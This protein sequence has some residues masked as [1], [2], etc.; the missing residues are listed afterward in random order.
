MSPI[1]QLESGQQIEFQKTPTP[2]DIDAAVA[3]SNESQQSPTG[4]P[5]RDRMTALSNSLAMT[6]PDAQPQSQSPLSLVE[7]IKYGLADEPGKEKLLKS[8]FQYVQPTPEGNHLVGDNPGDMQKVNPEGILTDIPAKLAQHVGDIN[9]IAMS[10][11]GATG[12]GAIGGVPGAIGGSAVGGAVAS[13]INKTIAR[14]LGLNTQSPMSV[15][16]DIAIDGAL[17]GAGEGVGQA[18][19]IGLKAAGKQIAKKGMVMAEQLI[20][21]TAVPVAEQAKKMDMLANVIH[22]T[23]GW[24]KEDVLTTLVNGANKTLSKD[25][26]GP[27]AGLVKGS[28]PHAL[29]LMDTIKKSVVNKSAD[30]D[31]AIAKS[32]NGLSSKLGENTVVP[33]IELQKNVFVQLDRMKLGKIVL[34]PKTGDASFLFHPDLNSAEKK[35]ADSL[36]GYFKSF[37]G[38]VSKVGND[39]R[40]FVESDA[41]VNIDG[42]LRNYNKVSREIKPLI[43]KEEGD[44]AQSLISIKS[45]NVNPRYGENVKGIVNHID[46]MADMVGDTAYKSAKESFKEF[47]L[48]KEMAKEAGIDFMDRSSLQLVMKKGFTSSPLL[49][50][51]IQGMDKYLGQNYGTQLAMWKAANSAQKMDANLLSF[52]SYW[53]SFFKKR[54]FCRESRLYRCWSHDRNTQRYFYVN[55]I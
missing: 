52:G 36:Q 28:D 34:D 33:T 30:L 11:L 27:F 41:K 54:F 24:N 2:E 25:T 1:V 51:A 7:S 42:L 49:D 40:M 17:M 43:K 55:E 53:F 18:I 9:T 48:L 46:D 19:N 37:G 4:N 29:A 5:I 8:K 38:G 45:G 31:S 22:F 15:A 14:A 44:F 3:Q 12:G 20:K 16:T 10:I 32:A 39:V 6:G 21:D 50:Q 13:G 26:T 23:S 47:A 35:I